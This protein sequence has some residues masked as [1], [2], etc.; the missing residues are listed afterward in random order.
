M[1][2][3]RESVDYG[4][5]DAI[6]GPEAL[7]YCGGRTIETPTWPVTSVS[8][9]INSAFMFCTCTRGYKVLFYL[10]NLAVTICQCFPLCLLM[11][12]VFI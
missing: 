2:R 1:A 8:I 10:Q 7:D 11:V 4:G 3:T 6:E 9:I 5:V 12:G